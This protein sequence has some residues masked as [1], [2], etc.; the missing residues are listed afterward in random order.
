MRLNA[1]P[2]A[3][4]AVA[5]FVDSNHAAISSALNNLISNS[6]RYTPRGGSISVGLEVDAEQ[7]DEMASELAREWPGRSCICQWRGEEVACD[8]TVGER[9]AHEWYQCRRIW[10]LRRRAVAGRAWAE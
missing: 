9:W 3:N 2:Q 6:V 5:V 7:V 1:T 10:D 8:T 4:A